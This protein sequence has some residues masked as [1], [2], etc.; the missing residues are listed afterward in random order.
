MRELRLLASG[1]LLL[2][3]GASC[4]SSDRHDEG[5]GGEDT[6]ECP[7]IEVCNTITVDDV[8]SACG[9][10]ATLF[11]STITISAD[12][13]RLPIVAT[14]SYD[15]TPGVQ[16]EHACFSSASLASSSFAARKSNL[17][18]NETQMDVTGIGE[19]AFVR[20]HPGYMTSQLFVL[21]ANVV[22][23]ATQS[24]VGGGQATQQCLRTLAGEAL[25]I[26]SRS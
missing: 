17:T 4:G 23:V 19:Q 18:G 21:Q 25:T 11:S 15:G 26:P 9:V 10:M 8:N 14:C 24:S 12:P 6:T 22:V 5:G 7:V 2:V 3:G 20:E 13:S 16:V 1:F